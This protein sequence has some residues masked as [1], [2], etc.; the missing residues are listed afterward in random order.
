MLK[1]GDVL[2]TGATVTLQLHCDTYNRIQSEIETLEREGRKAPEQLLTD[3]HRFFQ[4][5][6]LSNQETT[7]NA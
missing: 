3:R 4:A 1:L 2:Y 5:L 7:P 6:A